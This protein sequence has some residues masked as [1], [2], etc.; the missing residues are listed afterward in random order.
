VGREHRA[1][2]RGGHEHGD[3]GS[4]RGS[5]SERWASPPPQEMPIRSNRLCPNLQHLSDEAREQR[6]DRAA[7]RD[8]HPRCVEPI[9]V[10]AGSSASTNGVSTSR[11]APMPLHTTSGGLSGSVPAR[12]STRMRRRPT[13]TMRTSPIRCPAHSCRA[14]PRSGGSGGRR[15]RQARPRG[16]PT[17]RRATG[18]S[19]ATRSPARCARRRPTR[20]GRPGVRRTSPATGSSTC[21]LGG[22]ASAACVRSRGQA[23]SSRRRLGARVAVAR[24]DGR[25]AR[26]RRV[27]R[28][29]AEVDLGAEQGGGAG[30]GQRVVR[31]RGDKVAVQ[32][33]GHPQ[34]QIQDGMSN[35]GVRPCR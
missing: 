2:R 32:R 13:G 15:A 18:C 19:P 9:T 3:G 16:T 21:G 35:A 6:N 23:G 29:R 14:P 30:P 5:G 8:P 1:A 25:R 24:A 20:P 17:A 4:G 7:E 26:R 12:T 34:L 22:F 33:R 11:L 28:H 10:I 27:D 31:G